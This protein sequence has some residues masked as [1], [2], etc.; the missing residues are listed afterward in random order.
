MDRQELPALA[1]CRRSRLAIGAS[2]FVLA[3]F[4]DA[5]WTLAGLGG[6][7]SNEGNP[8]MRAVMARFGLETG[9]WLA[10]SLVGIA[11]VLI[12][13]RGEAEIRRKAGW[14][15]RVPMTPWARAW[16]KSGDRS[17]IAFIPLYGAAAFQLLAAAGWA[18]L[19]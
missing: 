3:A 11:C 7:L 10:K 19:R 16:M 5:R 9:L 15:W 6:E 14:I 2:F 13:F 8:V 18:V 17:W 1:A 12:A 4:V